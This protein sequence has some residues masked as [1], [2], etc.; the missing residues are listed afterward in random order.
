[1]QRF[2]VHVSIAG[3]VDK[4]PARAKALGCDAFQ[5]FVSNPRSWKEPQISEEAAESFKAQ[6]NE[7][8]LNPVTVHATYLPNLA[9]PESI[10]HRK[11][12]D[13]IKLQYI[14]ARDI[15]ADYL[16]LHPG[17]HKDSGVENGIKQISSALQEITTDIPDGPMW[18]LENTAGGG[19]TI[20]RNAQELTE[21]YNECN[22]GKDKMGVC[23]DTCHA[24]ASGIDVRE[25]KAFSSFCS[26]IEKGMYKGAIKIIHLNDSLTDFDAGKDRHQHIGLGNIGETGI[27]N[28]LTSK[29]TKN[30]AI[31]L[32]TPISD[33]RGDEDNLASARKLSK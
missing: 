13:H 16:V 18:L 12:T 5:L 9:N 7:L 31:I 26:A 11:A 20:G 33:D 21:L 10:P 17:S 28:V 23:L 15:G 30:L 24:F 8:S 4:A 22:L 25:Q 29:Y 6:L 3:G 32:E 2:G 1:M 19:N 27:H 14:A